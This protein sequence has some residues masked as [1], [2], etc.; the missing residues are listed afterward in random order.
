MVLC[1][2]HVWCNNFPR[3]DTKPAV[4][5]QQTWFVESAINPIY[6]SFRSQTLISSSSHYI[7]LTQLTQSDTQTHKT[8]KCDINPSRRYVLISKV[9]PKHQR[10]SSKR[11]K[12]WERG[13]GGGGRERKRQWL[14]TLGRG[15][16]VIAWLPSN[17]HRNTVWAQVHLQYDPFSVWNIHRSLVW[18]CRSCN[19]TLHPSTHNPKYTNH[20][21]PVAYSVRKN[22]QSIADRS[23]LCTIDKTVSGGIEHHVSFIQIYLQPVHSSMNSTMFSMAREQQSG[24]ERQDIHFWVA[25]TFKVQVAPLISY[26][27]RWCMYIYLDFKMELY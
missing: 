10:G 7:D 18:L 16:M 22:I 17:K 12:K 20:A 11:G 9:I 4:A 21:L 23:V 24:R 15:T 27:V 1:K 6:T 8:V 13:V 19:S 14:E 25:C 3:L 2:Q 5:H 26:W